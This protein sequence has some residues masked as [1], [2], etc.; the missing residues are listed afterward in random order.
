MNKADL[1]TALKDETELTKSEADA[2][3]H[4]FFDVLEAVPFAHPDPDSKIIEN[5][6][7]HN[8]R[9]IPVLRGSK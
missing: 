6:G 4:L 3:A 2:K 1:I 8:E 7:K 5:H 9:E